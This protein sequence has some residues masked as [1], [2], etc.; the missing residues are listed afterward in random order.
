ML[1]PPLFLLSVAVLVCLGGSRLAIPKHGVS[2]EHNH[3]STAVTAIDQLA[4]GLAGLEEED[5]TKGDIGFANPAIVHDKPRKRDDGDETESDISDYS[6]DDLPPLVP[7]VTTDGKTLYEECSQDQCGDVCSAHT[8][9]KRALDRRLPP[10]RPKP[11]YGQWVSPDDYEDKIGKGNTNAE[12]LVRG[13]VHRAWV[14]QKVVPLTPAKDDP[15]AMSTLSHIIKF[16]DQVDDLGAFGFWGCTSVVVV[17]RRGAWANRIFEKP[18]F[19]G[20]PGSLWNAGIFKR[21]AIHALREGVGEGT[22]HA[23]GIPHFRARGDMFGDDAEPKAFIYTPRPRPDKKDA[24]IDKETNQGKLL[25]P[26]GVEAIK[27]E[28]EKIFDGYSLNIEVVDYSPLMAPPGLSQKEINNYRV[29]KGFDTA[30][31][32]FLVQYRPAPD[33]MSHASWRIWFEGKGGKGDAWSD[34]WKPETSSSFNQV[35]KPK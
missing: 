26:K 31:G 19:R 34:E 13:E 4:V 29:D 20:D 24:N 28:L 12:K 8:A 32:K 14:K 11:P 35:L 30:R 6:G 25:Y 2:Q 7:V 27:K 5:V 23:F 22:A 17:S 10:W 16:A 9:S 15:I 18:T 33:Y 3:L 21:N 1:R